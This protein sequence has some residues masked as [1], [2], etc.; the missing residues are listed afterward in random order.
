MIF[1]YPGT[2]QKQSVLT[3]DFLINDNCCMPDD[4]INVHEF[5]F[6][7]AIFGFPLSELKI[8]FLADIKQDFLGCFVRR[9]MGGVDSDFRI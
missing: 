2:K 6:S 8:T 5:I 9:K 7:E 4:F 1:F 3:F